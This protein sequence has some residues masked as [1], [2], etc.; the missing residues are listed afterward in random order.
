M[1]LL[2]AA[3]FID[4]KPNP[5]LADSRIIFLRCDVTHTFILQGAEAPC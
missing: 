4:L 5:E 3:G 2:K 1:E